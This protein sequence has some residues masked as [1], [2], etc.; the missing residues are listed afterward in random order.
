MS[1][2]V[3]VD[4]VS[5]LP[6]RTQLSAGQDV[7]RGIHVSKCLELKHAISSCIK[8]VKPVHQKDQN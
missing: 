5:L 7:Q 6:L 4:W 3:T 2:T 8:Q 1:N